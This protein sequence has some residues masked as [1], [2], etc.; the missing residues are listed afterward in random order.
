MIEVQLALEGMA[1]GFDEYR[2]LCRVLAER[3]NP[4]A[5]LVAWADRDRGLHSPAC[6]QCEIGGE[7][8]WEV[9]GRNHGGRLRF[10]VNNG[11]YV[12]VYS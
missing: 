12:F 5:T 3:D 10:S 4:E 8:G 7:P 6:V 2:Q 11:A 9:Y 1:V